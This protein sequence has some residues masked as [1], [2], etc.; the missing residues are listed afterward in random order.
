MPTGL[1]SYLPD[2]PITLHEAKV[3]PEWLQW[4]GA[5]K[6]EMDGQIARGVW[7]VVDR[8]KGKIVL[9]TKSVFKR[10]VDQDGRAEKYNCRFVAKGFRQIKGIHYQESLSPTPTQSSIRMALAV[11][12]LLDWE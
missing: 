2:E 12:A 6:R 11:V 8:P 7:K 3:S 10:K 4:R 5:L 9:G 1:A